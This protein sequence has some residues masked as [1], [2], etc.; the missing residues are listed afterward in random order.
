MSENE[1]WAWVVLVA[2]A[3][4]LIISMNL[5]ERLYDEYDEYDLELLEKIGRRRQNWYGAIAI[6][7]AILVLISLIY[8]FMFEEAPITGGYM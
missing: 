8:I 6:I 1:V 2:S 5:R 7:S 4:S 3:V